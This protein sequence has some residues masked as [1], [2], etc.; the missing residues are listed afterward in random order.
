MLHPVMT[1]D[2]NTKAFFALVRAGLF[3]VHGEGFKVNDSLF[4]EVD[5]NEVYELAQEQSVLGLVLAGI[6]AVQGS[7]LK[8]HGSPL[9]PQMLLLQWIGE[10]Q[11]IEQR[12]KDMNAFIA[13]LI[14]KLRK[15][16]VYALLV[17]GQGVAQCYEKPLWRA[18]GDVDLLLNKDNYNKAK[19]ILVSAASEVANEDETTKHQALVINGF[20]VELHGKMPFSLSN[21]VDA[22][23]DDVLNDIFCRGNVRSWDCNGTQVF[24]PS[25][26]NDVILVFTH[27]LHHFFIEG[28]GLR[29]IC[30]WCRLLYRYRSELDLRLLES[31]I[32]RMGLM[33]E[34]KAFYNL[35]SRYLGMPDLGSGLM[36]HDSRFDKKADR[37]LALVLKSG[38]FGHNKD[39]SYRSRYSGMT[40]KI[41]AAWRRL[42]DFV[43]LIPVFPLDAPR[44]YVTYVMGKVKEK[45][46]EVNEAYSER[47]TL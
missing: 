43:S 6:E 24:L 10:V 11:I 19:S 1:L 9:V 20:D 30:D 40:Y 34:W 18:C 13:E 3:P 31:R 26:D 27:F 12:N 7:W 29:Q 44:F 35:A 4:R 15:R 14:E 46:R 39:L 41:V 37:I 25:P 36:V 38:N 45:S 32:K 17:K 47:Q 33:S 21:R 8:V 16:D 42:K 23:I 28:V 2:N 22:G 5:W